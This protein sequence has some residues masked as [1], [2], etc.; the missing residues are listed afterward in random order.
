MRALPD[1][2]ARPGVLG[3][4]HVRQCGDR[5]LVNMDAGRRRL[6]YLRADPRIS[7]TVLDE[8]DW[9][10]HVSM[11][12]RVVQLEEDQNLTDIDRLSKH[13]NGEGYKTR[14]RRRI[15]AWIV[16][17]RWHGW[18]AARRRRGVPSS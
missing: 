5:V 11:Q 4:E 1:A 14:D 9:Y 17:D 18:G 7:L 6:E 15:S 10:T 16:V 13:Y 2:V 3:T 12:G 8:T